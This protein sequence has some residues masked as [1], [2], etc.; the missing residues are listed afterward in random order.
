MWELDLL[1]TRSAPPKKSN[2]PIKSK[3]IVTL[4]IFPNSTYLPCLSESP[5]NSYCGNG[6]DKSD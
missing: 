2:S 5:E 6:V 1:Y 3:E 4:S